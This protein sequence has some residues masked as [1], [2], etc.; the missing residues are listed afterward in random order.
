M[1]KIQPGLYLSFANAV[2]KQTPELSED[3]ATGQGMNENSRHRDRPKGEIPEGDRVMSH[4][5]VPL[6]SCLLSNCP[7]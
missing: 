5:W 6:K 7:T 3:N 4:F 1:D 2:I